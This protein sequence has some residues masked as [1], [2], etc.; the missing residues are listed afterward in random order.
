MHLPGATPPRA[1]V[2]L[3]LEPPLS[4]QLST[5]EAFEGPP[6]ACDVGG[7]PSRVYS[8]DSFSLPFSFLSLNLRSASRFALLLLDHVAGRVLRP[9]N[10]MGVI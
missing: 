7:R 2:S 6:K 3:H 5:R 8:A 1:I 4:S 9:P 10:V